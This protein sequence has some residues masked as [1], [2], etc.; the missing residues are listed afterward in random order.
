[1]TI[2]EYLDSI[3]GRLLT[4]LVVSSF[5]VSRERAMLTDGYLRARLTLTDGS[6]LEFSEYAQRSP[7]AI[8]TLSPTVTTGPMQAAI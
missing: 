3:K 6:W 5:R 4:D 2:L 8:S 7:T 1:M